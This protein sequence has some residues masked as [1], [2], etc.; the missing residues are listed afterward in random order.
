[1]IQL[2]ILTKQEKEYF[3]LSQLP[4]VI[5]QMEELLGYKIEKTDQY[6]PDFEGYYLMPNIDHYSRYGLLT[7]ENATKIFLLGVVNSQIPL[8]LEKYKIA[9]LIQWRFFTK[10]KRNIHIQDYI[11]RKN[12]LPS[13]RKYHFEYSICRFHEF[14]GQNNA[15]AQ[16]IIKYLTLYDTSLNSN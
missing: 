9:G 6:D 1:M 10:T 15:L 4:E 11:I 8:V 3:S 2:K 14:D 12:S 13:F 16:S 7:T 5:K